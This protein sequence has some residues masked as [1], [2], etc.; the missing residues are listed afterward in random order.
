MHYYFLAS[1]NLEIVKNLF[2]LARLDRARS[3]IIHGNLLIVL[4]YQ[5]AARLQRIFQASDVG[6]ILD[7]GE[8]FG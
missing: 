5:K 7:R 3:C 6:F 2:C 1:Q 4:K 8:L